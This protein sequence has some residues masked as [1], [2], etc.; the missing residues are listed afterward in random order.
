METHRFVNFELKELSLE[1]S[2]FCCS[3]ENTVKN[4]KRL[5]KTRAINFSFCKNDSSFLNIS[6]ST[7]APSYDTSLVISEKI[8]NTYTINANTRLLYPYNFEIYLFLTKKFSDT[9]ISIRG[10]FTA[11]T[12]LEFYCEIL[13]KSTDFFNFHAFSCFDDDTLQELNNIL[14]KLKLNIKSDDVIQA[15][16][17][18]SE[19]ESFDNEEYS[20]LIDGDVVPFDD[21]TVVIINDFICHDCLGDDKTAKN[22]IKFFTSKSVYNKSTNG[23]IHDLIVPSPLAVK[24][25]SPILNSLDS[26][27]D[28]INVSPD[29]EFKRNMHSQ[30]T[31]INAFDFRFVFPGDPTAHT[32]HWIYNTSE[33]KNCVENATVL[34]APHHGSWRTAKCSKDGK[35]IL[36]EYLNVINPHNHIISSGK[37]NR[38]FH[39]KHEYVKSARSTKHIMTPAQYP[40]QIYKESGDGSKLM[41]FED[42]LN[43]LYTTV[44][45]IAKNL[46]SVMEEKKVSYM[47][48]LGSAIY[49][50]YYTPNDPHIP[51]TTPPVRQRLSFSQ[52]THEHRGGGLW[53]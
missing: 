3:E 18:S 36:E 16:D 42:E 25:I 8:L 1:I 44:A 38:F 7:N 22:K 35:T 52:F 32:M 51:L 2:H 21:N 33:N 31:I 15:L 23:G 37:E 24:I 50:K 46:E 40:H 26:S 12:V 6:F 5:D 4:G 11:A 9:R 28:L 34:S 47:F 49:F 30:A 10:E 48:N 19:T 29:T 13:K 27:T 20:G 43:P 14:Q 53:I 45:K 39:P 41:T 17:Q